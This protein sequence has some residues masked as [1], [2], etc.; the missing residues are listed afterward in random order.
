MRERAFVMVPLADLD[1]VW[2]A[3]ATADREAVRPSEVTLRV[4]E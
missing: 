4:P 1:P 2:S 3:A